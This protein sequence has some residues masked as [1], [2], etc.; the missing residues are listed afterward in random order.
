LIIPTRNAHELVRKCIGSILDKTLYKNYEIILLDNASDDPESLRYFAEL[1]AS[2]IRVIR[3][4]RPF[5]YSALNNLGVQQARGEIIGLIN[6]DVE[7]IEPSWLCEMV[8]HAERAEVGAVGAKL[9]YP[10]NTI[11][12]A[13]IVLGLGDDRIAGHAH[14]RCDRESPGYFGRLALISAFSAVTAA[15]LVVRREVFDKVGGLDEDNLGVA[16][17]DVDFCLKLR[18]AGYRNVYTPYALLYHHESASRG[19]EDTP[20]K[21]TRF[22]REKQFLR[23]KWGDKLLMDPAYS[24]NLAL[25]WGDFSLACP[26]RVEHLG[27]E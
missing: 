23:R 20:E 5:N 6:N 11:Q 22:S 9:L 19:T 7:V 18:E 1:T 8:S 16:Y 10:N 15:C 4:D 14:L 24:L 21:K 27:D 12:H 25:D 3:D 2:G 13:G 26:P 17:N